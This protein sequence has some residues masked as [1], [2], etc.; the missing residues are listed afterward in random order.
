MQDL[1][2]NA[3]KAENAE[4]RGALQNLMNGIDTG[5]VRVETDAD[6]TLANALGKIR[7]ILAKHDGRKP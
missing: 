3:L 5:L 4:L 7:A 6:E 1:H 2:V